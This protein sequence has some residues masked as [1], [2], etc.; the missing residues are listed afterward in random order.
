M[1][2]LDRNEAENMEEQENVQNMQDA[3]VEQDPLLAGYRP[4]EFDLES[5]YDEVMSYSVSQTDQV[6]PLYKKIREAAEREVLFDYQEELRRSEYKIS[7]LEEQAGYLKEMEEPYD[8]PDYTEEQIEGYRR[9][10]SKYRDQKKEAGKSPE[11]KNGKAALEENDL[12]VS[13]V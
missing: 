12:D 1:G 2:D 13:D 11:E 9:I 4:E 5:N 3:E 7:K 8:I 6:E 10:I